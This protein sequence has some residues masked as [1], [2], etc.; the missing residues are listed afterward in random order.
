MSVCA[1]SKTKEK[2]QAGS[3]LYFPPTFPSSIPCHLAYKLHGDM[4]TGY[5]RFACPSDASIR[6]KHNEVWEGLTFPTPFDGGGIL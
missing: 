2:K 5:N 1:V 3:M 4:L 6:D